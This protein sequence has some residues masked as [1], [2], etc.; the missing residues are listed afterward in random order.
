MK[1][2]SEGQ[3]GRSMGDK[4]VG[5]VRDSKNSERVGSWRNRANYATVLSIYMIW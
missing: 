5:G 1:C 4:R 3:E 2:G